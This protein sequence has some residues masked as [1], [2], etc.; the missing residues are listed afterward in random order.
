MR[1]NNIRVLVANF[2][3]CFLEEIS[4]PSLGVSP[5]VVG[6]GTSE[7]ENPINQ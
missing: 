6:I 7:T 3:D 4:Q 1:L 2:D 5:S